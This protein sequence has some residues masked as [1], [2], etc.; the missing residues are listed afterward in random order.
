MCSFGYMGGPAK[1]P[2]RARPRGRRQADK[3]VS[4]Q[5]GAYVLESGLPGFVVPQA[6]IEAPDS[7]S[8]AFHERN[9]QIGGFRTKN[10][11]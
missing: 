9:S 1:K 4:S 5:F 6:I 2:V 8:S 7:A 11:R 10:R 3:M